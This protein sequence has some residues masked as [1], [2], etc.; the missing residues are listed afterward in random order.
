MKLLMRNNFHA[1]YIFKIYL[2]VTYVT[3]YI[4]ERDLLNSLGNNYELNAK[5]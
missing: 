1:S 4:L 5:G 2:T 3:Y